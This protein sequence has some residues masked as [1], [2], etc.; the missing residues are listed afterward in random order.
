MECKEIGTPKAVIRL[1]S[2]KWLVTG[3]FY[4]VQYVVWTTHLGYH[5][6]LPHNAAICAFL[7]N[8]IVALSWQWHFPTG[9]R[10]N[11][12]FRQRIVAYAFYLFWSHYVII[13]T[14]VIGQNTIPLFPSG[15]LWLIGLEFWAIKEF[16][17]YVM[18]K[19]INKSA[20]SN[21]S[22]AKGVVTLQLVAYT[23]LTVVVFISTV[24]YQKI[25]ACFIAVD[26]VMNSI[27]TW[28]TIKEQHKRV[29]VMDIISGRAQDMT[30]Q[31]LT[32]LIIN[33][34]ME[35]LVP[36]MYVASV[37]VA[38]YGPNSV[39][40]G[41]IGL[42]YWHFENINDIW[43]YL[44]GA[45]EMAFADFCLSIV[46]PF[47]VWKFTRINVFKKYKEVAKKFGVTA[48]ILLPVIL[49]KVRKLF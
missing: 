7:Q 19:L 12:Q 33:E 31:L 29:G 18:E 39:N 48:A 20:G 9:L 28:K 17:N 44:S 16:N 24:A 49:N 46:S 47:L 1:S 41:N 21:D 8:L 3:T 43:V 35:L 22:Y 42:S 6:P 38:F 45:L 25:T 40:L 11:P 2:I 36:L 23:N 15:Y 30:D 14:F 10:R 5:Q 13:L 32:N 34:S 26:F 37:A 27:L 4:S